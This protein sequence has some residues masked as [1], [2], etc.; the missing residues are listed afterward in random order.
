MGISA[1][2]LCVAHCLM[3]P[4]SVI[5][6]P[7]LGLGFLAQEITHQILALLLMRTGVCAFIPG[8][9]RHGR[10]WVLAVALLSWAI[11]AFAAF[12]A[13][14]MVGELWETLFTLSASAMLIGAHLKNLS[15]CRLYELCEA[16][17]VCARS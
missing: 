12:A 13:G 5:F 17:K 11:L 6:L 2:S 14:E 15:F 8:Y 16:Q 3:L 9:R 10:L 4:L 1:S 7:G